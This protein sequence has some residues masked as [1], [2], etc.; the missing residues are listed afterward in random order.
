[1]ME[2]VVQELQAIID[3]PLQIDTSN[4]KAME[5]AIGCTTEKR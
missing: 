4:M 5:R 3:L 2:E 1:M